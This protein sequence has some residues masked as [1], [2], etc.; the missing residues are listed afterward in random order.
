MNIN[1]HNYESFFMLYIDKELSGEEKQAVDEFVNE[2]AD[3]KMELEQLQL[4]VLPI[5]TLSFENKEQLFKPEIITA[6]DQE[7]LLLLLDGELTAAEILIIEEKIACQPALAKEWDLLKRTR[8]DATTDEFVFENKKLLYRKEEKVRP[9]YFMVRWAVAAV[10]IGFGFYAGFQ[11]LQKEEISL[12]VKNANVKTEQTKNNSVKN[13]ND[14]LGE[15]AVNNNLATASSIKNQ[16]TEVVLK[17]KTAATNTPSTKNI[18]IEKYKNLNTENN[19]Q[20]FEKE[21]VLLASNNQ[22]LKIK[23]YEEQEVSPELTTK[24]PAKRPE[25]VDINIMDVQKDNNAL[26]TAFKDNND[27]DRILY[28]DKEVVEK[29]KVGKFLKKLKNNL[30]GDIEVKTGKTLKI[31]GF[32]IALK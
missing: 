24:L 6:A 17:D 18:K 20:S 27:G 11:L 13:N 15:G 8:L 9:L 31:A 1:R 10:V 16:T 4:A 28:M 3:L 32:E 29:T 21:P 12:P 19:K 26:L 2:H 22:N 14:S 25:L 30:A 23:N 5:E 7:N